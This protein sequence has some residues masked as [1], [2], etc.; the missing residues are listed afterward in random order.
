M[1]ELRIIT[2][3]FFLPFKF[4]YFDLDDTLLDH[5][6]AERAALADVH[7]H[8]SLFSDVAPRKLADVYH[9]VNSRQ[10]MQYSRGELSREQLQRNRFEQ[11]LQQLDLVADRHRDVGRFYMN[12]YRNHWQW[13]DGAK[14]M[15]RQVSRQYPVGIV[16]NGFAETQRKKFEVFEFYDSADHV[17]ISEDVGALKP[18]PRVFQYAT[19]L[20]GVSAEQILY[21][22]DSFTSDIEGGGNFGWKTAWYTSNG[23]TEK[24][25]VASFVFSDYKDLTDMLI[26]LN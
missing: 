21:V 13:I 15:Y 3:S 23:D 14:S 25:K 24:H 6:A 5:G 11:T 9:R 26:G 8:F 7:E 19:D 22:G 17:V 2:Q 16:T 20:T 18:D 4:I 12:C 1:G 10:W